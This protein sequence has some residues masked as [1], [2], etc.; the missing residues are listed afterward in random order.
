MTIDLPTVWAIVIALGVLIYVILDGFDLGIGLLYPLFPQERERQLMM[1]TVAPVWDGNETWMVLGGAGL[2]AAFPAVYGGLLSATYLPLVLMLC[3]LIFRG[4]AFELRAKAQRTRHAWD[5]AFM[6]GSALA[7]FCQGMVLGTLLQGIPM[8]AGRYTGNGMEWLSPFSFFCGLGLCVT[9]ACLG[10]GWLIGKTGG[11]LQRKLLAVMRPLSLL[12]LAAIAVISVWTMLAQPRVSAR[13]FDPAN[14]FYFLP[15]PA[16]LVLAIAGIFRATRRGLDRQPFAYAIGIVFLGFS[17]LMLSIFPYILPGSM[18]IWQ[19]SSPRSSQ[20]FALVGV[21]VVLPVI[22][23]YT[24]LSYWVF[25]GKVASD[26]GY[27]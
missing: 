15:V 26:S 22:L 11:E 14:F 5:I 1:N 9:Y 18:D 20:G 27:H 8:S 7:T 16:L 12:L 25:R 10:C 3:G 21:I 23:A 4:A 17:G 24:A 13:W 2:Y 6:G 19:A